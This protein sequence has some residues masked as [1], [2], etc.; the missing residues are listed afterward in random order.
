MSRLLPDAP[1]PL[2]DIMDGGRGPVEPPIRSEIFGPQR[3]AEHGRSLGATHRATLARGWGGS[4]F[5]RLRDNILVLREA[6]AYI[7]QQAT[8]GYDISP[9][10]EW[11]LDNFHL[12]DAQLREIREGLP[13]SYFRAL[14]ILQDPPLAGLPRVYGIAWAFV[15]H[16]DGAFD[17]ELLVRFLAAY[18]ET[19]ELKLSEV[20]ALPTTLRVVLVENLRR[21]AE[22]VATTKAARA[23]ANLCCDRIAGTPVSTLDELL[24]WMHQ[25]GAGRVF[26][27]QMAQRFQ[28]HRTGADALQLAWL[29]Q[30]MPD[31][32]AF[33][34]Q[35]PIDQAADNLSVSNAVTSL[36]AIGGA[37]WP[38]IVAR[39]SYLMQLMRTSEVFAAEDLGTRDQTLHAIERLARANGHSEVSVAQT[40]LALMRASTGDTAVASHWLRGP[41]RPELVNA[42]GL[43]DSPAIAWR[44]A[45]RH[46]VVPVYLGTLALGTAGLVSWMLLGPTAARLEPAWLTLLGVLLMLFPASEAVVAVINRLIS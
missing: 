5:P 41:G 19:R 38:D 15:A 9:A 1:R 16:T 25:R 11:L 20:W 32:A 10:A 26:L 42:L 23:V 27:V 34:A 22:R 17:E 28:D 13:R 43:H 24:L 6:H 36:R 18:Q 31:P 44:A 33:L 46:M 40:L 45:W 8:T 21:L 7:A 30:E 39:T 29:Q 35:Q 4:F 14:P 3:F 37:D 2:R 12:I